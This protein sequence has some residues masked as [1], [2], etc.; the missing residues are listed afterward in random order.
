MLTRDDQVL[1][2]RRP[3]TGYADGQWNVPSVH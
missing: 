2:A 3:G 1:L